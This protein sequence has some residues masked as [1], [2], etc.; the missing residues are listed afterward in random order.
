LQGDAHFLLRALDLRGALAEEKAHAKLRQPFAQACGN[1]RVEKRQDAI[2]AVHQRHFRA[3]RGE[4]GRVF[5]A[6]HAAAHHREAARNR[7]HFQNGV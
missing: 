4:D 5:A 3:Q 6:D 7:I 2:A 1:F